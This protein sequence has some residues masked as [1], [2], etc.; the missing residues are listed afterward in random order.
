MF[1]VLY[2]LKTFK[3]L[4]AQYEGKPDMIKRGKIFLS[5]LSI[6]N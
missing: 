5:E 4:L 3:Q 2:V 1:H 6:K